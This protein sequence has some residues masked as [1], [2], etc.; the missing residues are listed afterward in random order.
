MLIFTTYGKLARHKGA[1]HNN[2][3]NQIRAWCYIDDLISAMYS[4]LQMTDFK[5]RVSNPGNPQGTIAVF[6]LAERLSGS[7]S[8]I[9]FKPHPGPKV[10]MRMPDIRKAE[11]MLGFSP[12]IC[13]EEGLA[14][15]IEW[16]RHHP[17]V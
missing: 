10:E 16:Y 6:G 8:K 5:S 7:G 2:D 17:D 11:S 1:I 12:R 14:L 9:I 4:I 15:S 3:G 13:L